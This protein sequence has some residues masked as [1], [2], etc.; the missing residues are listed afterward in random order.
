M[1][2]VPNIYYSHWKDHEKAVG[3]S[4]SAVVVEKTGPS[5]LRWDVDVRQ[6]TS[7]VYPN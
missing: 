4:I 1:R 3:Y 7:G 5:N 6:A 2:L